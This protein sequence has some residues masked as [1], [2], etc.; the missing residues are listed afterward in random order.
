MLTQEHVALGK[1]RFCVCVCVCAGV[2]GDPCIVNNDFF[3]SKSLYSE[4]PILFNCIQFVTVNFAV[5]T[6]LLLYS[7]QF[8][9]FTMFTVCDCR[10][11]M[12]SGKILAYC[13]SK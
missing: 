9:S 8:P 12:H 10:F 6:A 13:K 2:G 7:R 3:H 1:I 4:F 5:F 11:S